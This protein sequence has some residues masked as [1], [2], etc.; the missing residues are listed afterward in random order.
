MWF[1]P[2]DNLFGE[3]WW[4]WVVIGLIWLGP[5]VFFRATEKWA[6]RRDERRRARNDP[7][8]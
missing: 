2:R 6:N 3:P 1:D 8:A 5:F 4:V 7:P